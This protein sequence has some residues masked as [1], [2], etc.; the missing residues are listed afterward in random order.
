MEGVARSSI[1]TWVSICMKL[2]SHRPVRIAVCLV[3]F[4]VQRSL[5][6]LLTE[7]CYRISCT[8][9]PAVRHISD[10]QLAIGEFEVH[11]SSLASIVSV[12]LLV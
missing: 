7:I 8:V 2:P 5:L 9:P 11:L 3:L 10:C 4:M 6:T 12:R 1:M